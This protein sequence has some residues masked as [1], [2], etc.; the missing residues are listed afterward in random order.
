MSAPDPQSE[1]FAEDELGKAYD[2]RI[3][4]RLWPYVRPY[5]RQIAATLVLFVPLFALELAPAWIVKSGIDHVIEVYDLT[6]MEGERV[7]GQASP[8][9]SFSENIDAS[10][11]GFLDA[12]EGWAMA[13]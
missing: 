10:L 2:T 6:P 9:S 3:L 4:M 13:A 1:A 5:R 11:G 7:E 12:P 8:V